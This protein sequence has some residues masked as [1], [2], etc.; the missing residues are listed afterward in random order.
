MPRTCTRC[1]GAG[2]IRAVQHVPYKGVGGLCYRCAGSGKEP[3]SKK[4]KLRKANYKAQAE[5]QGW[6][7]YAANDHV[8]LKLRNGEIYHKH[9]SDFS[10]SDSPA[11]IA[12]DLHFSPSFH[13]NNSLKA[14]GNWH[15]E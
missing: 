1:N 11:Q 12:W 6:A 3:L 13:P 15:K 5:A 7:F 2:I 10:G 4:D 9:I 14:M 8:V